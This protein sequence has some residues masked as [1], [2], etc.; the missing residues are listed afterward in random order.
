MSWKFS[1]NRSPVKR[2]SSVAEPGTSAGI[3]GADSGSLPAATGAV[4]CAGVSGSASSA[5][6]WAS[7]P[8]VVHMAIHVTDTHAHRNARSLYH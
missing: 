8:T 6:D 4:P 7:A 1:D 3:G 5:G 2:G